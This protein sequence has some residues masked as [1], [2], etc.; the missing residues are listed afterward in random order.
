MVGNLLLRGLLVGLL[1][2]I[3]AYGFAFV[4]GEPHVDTAIAFEELLA[5]DE[6]VDPAAEEEGEIVSRS[7]QASIGLLTGVVVMAVGLGG[8]FAILF[9]LAY[10]RL[11]NLGI[12]QTSVLLAALGFLTVSLVPWL[13]YPASPPASTF[14]DTIAFRSSVYF[15]MLALSI[16][17]T[18]GAWIVRKQ[19][20]PRYGS[21]NA[22]VIAAVGYVIVTAIVM[23]I[24]PTIN[25]TPDGFPVDAFWDFRIAS[26][27][28]HA[29]LWGVIGVVFGV[30]VERT[31]SL[32]HAAPRRGA[33]AA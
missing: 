5:A 24:M 3:L 9:A 13:K 25:E 30:V 29:V 16:A 19:L 23:L 2:G 7:T 17:L 6:P 15:L 1:A 33:V 4:F 11:G 21:W 27:G 26:L 32:G 12:Q 14:D 31:T 28:I 10:G 20:V 8:V 22:T 18:V